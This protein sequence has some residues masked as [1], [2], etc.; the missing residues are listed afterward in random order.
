M[1][2]S[3][4]FVLSLLILYHIVLTILPLCHVSLPFLTFSTQGLYLH[5]I[6]EQK[7]RT[8]VY[9]SNGTAT[10]TGSS[11]MTSNFSVSISHMC[12]RERE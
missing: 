10:G 1:D 12:V 5:R 3:L 9:T 7:T 11:V 4:F 8:Y 6:A 2:T